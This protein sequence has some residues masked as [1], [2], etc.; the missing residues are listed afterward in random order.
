M[1]F[2]ASLRGDLTMKMMGIL[3]VVSVASSVPRKQR[4]KVLR[5]VKENSQHFHCKIQ[6]EKQ[7]LWGSPA[8]PEVCSKLKHTG[9]KCYTPPPPTPENALLEGGSMKK[10]GGGE[11]SC[12]G[13][14]LQDV[15]PAPS[16]SA[17]KM[18]SGQKWGGGVYNFLENP[19]LLK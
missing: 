8:S 11:N 10:D 15:H 2:S 18:P 12:C 7:K 4:R 14:G 6:D 1:S 13:G 19:I 9:P 5:K 3:A 16:T 17:P